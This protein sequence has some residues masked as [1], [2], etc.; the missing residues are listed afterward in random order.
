MCF[1]FETSVISYI[2]AMFS[3][4]FAFTTRQIV[5][6][7]LILSYAQMQLS[8]LLIWKGIDTNNSRLNML[9]TSIGKYFL[10][11]HPLAIGI[12]I[13]LSILLV[14]KRTLIY[15]DFIPLLV[16]IGFFIFIVVYYY[17]PGDYN[18]ETAQLKKCTEENKCNTGDNRLFWPFPHKW[19]VSGYLITLLI[20]FIW[21]KPVITQLGFL[22]IFTLTFILTYIIYPKTVGS[23]WCWSTS[24]IAPVI[25]I[26][27]WLF[28]KNLPNSKILA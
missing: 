21:I 7:C 8:E 1:S 24:A 22:V 26:A 3:A 27:G 28:I 16:G 10:A 15:T 19:Y 14:S 12:G 11:T 17:L 20:V 13:I 23:V 4:I 5:L 18:H 2:L 9:G 25:S 6:G